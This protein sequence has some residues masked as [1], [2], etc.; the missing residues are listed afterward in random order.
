[1]S[2]TSVTIHLVPG[3]TAPRYD[4]GI[5]EAELQHV[6]ITEQGT[7]AHLPIVDIVAVLPD[8]NRVLIA[9]TGRVVN[10]ISAAVKGVNVRNHGVAEP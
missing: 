8:G 4:G 7:Q 10:M 5:V 9:C 2:E 3:D 6:T 1:M